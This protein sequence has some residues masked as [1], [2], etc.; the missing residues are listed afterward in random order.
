M[1]EKPLVSLILCVKNGMPF[2]PQA[3]ATVARQTYERFELVVQDGQS[4]D[5]SLELLREFRGAAKVSLESANDGGIG[6][7]YNRA[8]ERSRGEIIASIDADNLLA[9]DALQL[10]VDACER[11]PEAAAVYG[12]AH[13]IAPTGEQVSTFEPGE[14]ELVRLLSCELVPPF[15]T[16]FFRRS[17]CQGQMRFDPRLK[18]CADFDLWLRLSDKPVRRI[19][20]VLGS[21][22]LSSS[23]MTCR[24]ETYDQFCADK[25]AALDRY[26]APFEATPPVAALDRRARAGVYL[27]AAE[28]L[29]GMEGPSQRFETYCERAASFDP[30][31]PR[32]T[33]ARAAAEQVRQ[34]A[35]TPP[36]KRPRFSLARAKSALRGLAKSVL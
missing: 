14:F 36:V 22:R 32:L 34:A 1:A 20:K 2:L 24:P 31:S 10:G 19:D 25:L 21:T 7:A 8:V 29:L 30:G 18:T 11:W 28:S 23:S 6:P 27:W 9:D 33:N 26:F 35:A 15:A 13:L 17:A 5:G 12:S 3:L 4:N 16:S